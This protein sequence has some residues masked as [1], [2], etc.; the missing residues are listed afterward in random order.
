MVAFRNAAGQA[1][2]SNWWSNDDRQ[3]AFAR[4]GKGFLVMN[5]GNSPLSM[6]LLTT[7]PKGTYCDVI[8]GDFVNG[9]CTGK[10]VD[11]NELGQAV[12]RINS[13]QQEPMIA[14]HI[15]KNN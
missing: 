13:R 1:T 4:Q 3:F 9:A 15:G 10:T 2:L 6:A 5:A 8:S 14:I 7:L 11:V 12:F